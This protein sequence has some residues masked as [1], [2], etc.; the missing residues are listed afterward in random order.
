[1]A[2]KQNKTILSLVGTRPE[3]IKMAPILR[4]MGERKSFR[5]VICSTGQHREILDQS[6]ALF[7]LKADLDLSVM[8]TNHTLGQL[9]AK[10]F[11]AID[12][13]ITELKPDGI[14]AQGDTTSVFVAS[15][16]A[17]YHKIPFFHVEAG[18]RTGDIQSP[19]PEELNRRVADLVASLMFAP[20]THAADCL[21]REGVPPS[22]IV[23]SGNTV[24]DSL[25]LIARQPITFDGELAAKLDRAR[26]TVLVTVHRRENFGAGLRDIC[27]AIANLA[28]RHAN[29]QFVIPVH[30]NPNVK[31]TVHAMLGELPNV[32]LL[33]PLKYDAL[34]NLMRV[35]C[36]ILT[37]SGGIQEEAPSFG[38]PLFVLRDSTERPEG[39][40]AGVAKLVGPGRAAIEENVERFFS[41]PSVA[42]GMRTGVNPYGDGKA[43]TRILDSIERF[44]TAQPT[45][46]LIDRP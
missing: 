35:S 17:F 45:E 5:S 21:R 31:G 38:V 33:A 3:V 18:L 29:V 15:V 22:R 6:M 8:T 27:Q 34:I 2:D 12:P 7:G 20:T 19:F 10:L 16:L 42:A 40:A 14:I 26:K 9:T 23:L 28:D 32:L 39:V 25:Q 4:A 44:L 30:P 1:M 13:V 11:S 24:V 41:D 37:D 46:T 36:L 43:T